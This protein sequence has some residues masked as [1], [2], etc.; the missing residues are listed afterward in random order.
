M[1]RKKKINQ[2]YKSRMKKQ[3]AKLH[4]NKKPGYVSKADRAKL[5]SEQA[6]ETVVNNNDAIEAQDVVETAP[7]DSQ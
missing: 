1:N 4:P 6:A 3:N 7:A 5:E 2:I